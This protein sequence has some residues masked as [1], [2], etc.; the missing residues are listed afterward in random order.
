MLRKYIFFI[1]IA[2]L[3]IQPCAAFSLDLQQIDDLKKLEMEMQAQKANSLIVKYK[4]DSYLGKAFN[5]SISSDIAK[6]SQIS[7]DIELIVLQDPNNS[8]RIMNELKND[9]NVELVETNTK[10][11]PLDG[12]NNLPFDN[13]IED[14]GAAINNAAG[15]NGVLSKAFKQ[16]SENNQ[17]VNQNN[18]ALKL[19]D[20]VQASSSTNETE[21]NNSESTADNIAIDDTICGTITGAYYDLDYF[22]IDIDQAGELIIVGL[23]GVY[24]DYSEYLGIGLFDDNDNFIAESTLLQD[25]SGN[26]QGLVQYVTPGTYYIV[27]LQTSP[28]EYLL[29]G[30]TYCFSTGFSGTNTPVTAVE[31]DFHKLK[32]LKNTSQVLSFYIDPPKA[33]NQEVNWSSSKSTVASVDSSG[34]VTAKNTGSATITVTTQDGGKKDQCL[35]EV[36]NSFPVNDP[37][38]GKQWG[39]D[40]INIVDAWDYIGATQQK[41]A[42]VAVI[43]TGIDTSH[44]DLVNRIAPNG[45]NFIVDNNDVYD[46]NGHGTMVSGTIGAQTNN[47]KGMAGVTGN[48]NIKILPLQAGDFDGN[49]YLAD[50][51]KAID[52]AV[53]QGVDVIN[54]SYGGT[55]SSPIERQS[56]Q[57]AIDNG[58]IVVASAGNS[59]SSAYEYPASYDNVLS[60]GSISEDGSVSDFSQHND[61]ID[62]VAPGNNIYTTNSGNIYESVDGTSFSAPIVAGVIALMKAINPALTPAEINDAL[63]GTAIDKGSTGKDNYYGYGLID[64]FEAVKA[65]AVTSP[66]YDMN[67]DDIVD[68]RDLLFIASKIGAV[69]TDDSIKAD[70][71]HDNQVNILDLLEVEDNINL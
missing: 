27:I 36:V 64:S 52:Y 60:I 20:K 54:I 31:L 71:N 40:A 30:E 5:N 13:V 23:L 65:A 16:N 38:F 10:R 61:K 53:Q 2:L 68:I 50:Q 25:T 56:I 17:A 57:N 67:D 15:Y 7:A 55:T 1:V 22:E 39:L 33:A 45:Y 58:I 28:Y 29:V 4:N 43:D 12:L 32:M 66:S 3:L 24:T 62:F 47:N 46:I 59:G 34:K 42:I 8:S 11:Y 6:R 41:P 18:N 14:S 49:M 51:I 69:S 35:V 37:G 26:F 48:I 9:P 63:I 21:P 70:V 19:V 44:E